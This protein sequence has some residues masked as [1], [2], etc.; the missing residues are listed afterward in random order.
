MKIENM[1]FAR[2][3]FLPEELRNFG[4]TERDGALRYEEELLDGDFKAVL[5][6]RGG[7]LAGTVIDV[8]NGEEYRALR[9]EDFRGP[10]V[11]SVRAAYEE[12][13]RRVEE[14]CCVKVFFSS[15]Q[16]NR[17]AE[18]IFRRW[19][20]LADFPFSDEPYDSA[21]VFRHPD[22]GKWF[23]LVMNVRRGV[24]TGEKSEASTD[25]INLKKAPGEITPARA[26]IYPAYHMNHNTW[27]SVTLDERLTD[28]EVM[29]LIAA[30]FEA[31]KKAKKQRV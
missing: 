27:I 15:D 6:V 3:R 14:S 2:C 20:V 23:G 1:I 18:M 24:L 19:G 7:V 22:T 13:L 31:T 29:E 17:V 4:F 9:I 25:V 16:S 11:A 8:M 5:T 26:G 30:S 12:L 28:T 10:Y 21:G